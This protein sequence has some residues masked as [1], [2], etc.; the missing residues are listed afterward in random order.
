MHHIILI[1]IKLTLNIFVFKRSLISM[2]IFFDSN[3]IIHVQTH[4]RA[5]DKTRQYRKCSKDI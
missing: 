5:R 2:S 1:S 3:K 4:D